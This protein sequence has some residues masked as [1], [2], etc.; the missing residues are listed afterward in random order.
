M[1]L[2][3]AT[4]LPWPGSYAPQYFSYCWG[5]QVNINQNQ[6]LYAVLGVIYGGDA[7]TYFK[8][9]DL[10]GR[11]LTGVGTI[12][13]TPVTPSPGVFRQG[14]K[15]DNQSYP[16]MLTPNYLPMHTHVAAFTPTTG[17]QPVTIPAVP[18][19]GSVTASTTIPIVP[20]SAGVNPGN[21]TPYYLTGVGAPSK[22]PCTTT[23]P[24]PSTQST[25]AGVTTTLTAT[26]NY[27]T[28]MPQQTVNITTLTGGAVTVQPGG[29]AGGTQTPLGMPSLQPSLSMD[30]IICIAGLYPSRD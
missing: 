24:T 12:P 18:P 27:T 9:P 4:I 29:G 17:S 5:Q 10:Q 1:D 2:Y 30:F 26:S 20:G 19:A 7:K 28:G 8:L 11:V 6:A 23:A 16:T 25:V 3:L 22:G 15:Y 21:S 14:Q 13:G